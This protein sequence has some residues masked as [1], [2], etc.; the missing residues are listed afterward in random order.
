MRIL[1]AHLI[2]NTW[3]V[4]GFTFTV[5]STRAFGTIWSCPI[6][7]T[8]IVAVGTL[9]LGQS[10]NQR[11]RRQTYGFADDDRLTSPERRSRNQITWERVAFIASGSGG[12]TG[13]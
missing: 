5:P 2:N 13:S 9:I 4:S 6:H 11:T 12:T 10:I 8:W 3:V 7:H 1:P